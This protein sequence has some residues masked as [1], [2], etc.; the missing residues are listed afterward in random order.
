MNLANIT[1]NWFNIRQ[2]FIKTKD[3]A[4][5]T[6]LP[7]ADQADQPGIQNDLLTSAQM[8]ITDVYST[9]GKITDLLTSQK[10]F[11]NQRLATLYGLPYTGTT[12]TPFAAARPGRQ[13]RTGPAF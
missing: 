4:L 5:L 10:V 12:A 3:P 7:A 11:V 2:M 8:F 1:L 6:S 13:P 9:T